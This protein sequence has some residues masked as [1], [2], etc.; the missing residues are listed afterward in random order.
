MNPVT[1]IPSVIGLAI[2]VALFL[3]RKR[4]GKLNA[5]SWLVIFGVIVIVTEHPQFAIT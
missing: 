2:V 4:M 3:T 1:L 5:A